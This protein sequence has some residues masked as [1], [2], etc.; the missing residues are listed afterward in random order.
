MFQ[1]RKIVIW[2]KDKKLSPREITFKLGKVNVITGASRTG[3]S[4]IIPI[5]DY[6]LASD[7]CVIPI[8]TIRN[9][10]EWYGVI[11]QTES[12]QILIARRVPEGR[13]VSNDFFIER[14][15][16]IAV[17]PIIDSSNSKEVD[18][19][20]ALNKIVAAPFF[21]LG[22]DNDQ[23]YGARLSIRDLM[24]LIFQSQE[25]VANQNILFYKTHSHVH[26]EK[27][28]NWFPYILGA[29]TIDVLRARQELKDIETK[30]KRLRRE[31]D[32]IQKV[33][34]GWLSNMHGLLNVAKEYGLLTEHITP[35]TNPEE[36]IQIAKDIVENSSDVPETSEKNI[37]DFNK[38]HLE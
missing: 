7:H 30:L 19:K 29:E 17:P 22:T 18:I 23:N 36:L 28:R 33:S 26:R 5:I 9:Y 11:L 38:G 24:A 20:L 3:K 35:D 2:P 32:G 27:L 12:E 4:A 1:I 15:K 21:S 6:C 14:G 13:N 25:I 10:A 37:D 31:Y 16:E 8:D 34:L